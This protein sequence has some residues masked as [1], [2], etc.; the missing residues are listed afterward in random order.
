MDQKWYRLG[1]DSC[2]PGRT[3]RTWGTF[4]PRR[5]LWRVPQGLR[6]LSEALSEVVLEAPG[7]IFGGPERVQDDSRD[8]ISI[9]S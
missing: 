7:S 4:G 1:V 5:G 2:R 9:L 8:E 6:E 3:D